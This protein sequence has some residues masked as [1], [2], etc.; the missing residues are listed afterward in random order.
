MITW[1]FHRVEVNNR[2]SY[3]LVT[4]LR[5]WVQATGNYAESVGYGEVHQ[6]TNLC[7]VG[8]K[9]RTGCTFFNSTDD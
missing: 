9:S 5:L 8:A 4:L 3:Q 7:K 6:I 2:A 1:G